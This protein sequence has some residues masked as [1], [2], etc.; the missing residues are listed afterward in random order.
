M[1]S[2]RKDDMGMAYIIIA[3]IAICFV[4][5][6]WYTS[7]TIISYYGL[8]WGWL[9]LIP[10]DWSFMPEFIREWKHQII[11]MAY[12]PRNVTFEALLD[13]LNKVGYFFIWIPI[14]LAIRGI[15]I[16]LNHPSEKTRR[17][18]NADTLPWIMAKHSP[19]VTPALYYGNLLNTNP[20]EHK[21]ALSP[22]D[23]AKEHKLIENGILN[24]ERTRELFI[25]DL[26]RRIDS[27][28]KLYDHEKVLFVV[29]ASRIFIKNIASKKEFGLAQK[30][31]DELNYSCHKGVFNGKKGYPIFELIL[32]KFEKFKTHSQAKSWLKKH[33]YPR[34]LLHS[35]H[36]EALT[37][38]K[39]PSSHFRWLKGI[40]RGLWYALN[41]T[42]RKTPFV[43]SAAVFTQTLW[44]EFAD[45]NGYILDSPYVDDAVRGL[46][47][48][49][50]KVGLV[51]L[52]S[53]D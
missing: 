34:T 8:K 3:G 5:Y 7:H 22:D 11:G 37:R 6:F 41:T 36:K 26:G 32:P 12:N 51:K 43:E 19:A 20:E 14:L 47:K 40:D 16:T 4:V 27:L 9:Q 25:K 29:F 38:G 53:E 10:F 49:L 23:L 30:M 13:V 31:L 1:G 52:N 42:G 35:M 24:K 39:L 15:K 46:E 28:E 45:K 21:S 18:I 50:E 2:P 33:P 48:Y 44:E 17:V